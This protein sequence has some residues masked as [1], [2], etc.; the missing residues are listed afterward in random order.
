MKDK[1]TIIRM[2]VLIIIV[3]LLS[4][5]PYFIIKD[6][7]KETPVT[8]EDIYTLNKIKY[9]VP[10][11]FK[12]HTNKFQE[13]Y[14]YYTYSAEDAY[15]SI[16]IQMIEN[17]SNVYKNGEDYIKRSI[18]IT[19]NDQVETYEENEWFGILI[20]Q[21]ERFAIEKNAAIAHDGN[22][23][24]LKYQFNDY[25]N[26]EDESKESFKKCDTAY[27]YVFKSIKFQK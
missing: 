17:E 19:L 6:S 23:Y 9:E 21:K 24:I 12:K 13:D 22:I 20:K 11:G 16:E 3:G 8:K 26:G 1:T 25:S 18:Y 4:L 2:V 10:A 5:I 7:E 14:D 15:C 27:D